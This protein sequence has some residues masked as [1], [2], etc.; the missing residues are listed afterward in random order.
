MIL[1]YI[2]ILIIFGFFISSIYQRMN[3]ID[4]SINI[5][6]K[7]GFSILNGFFIFS[8]YIYALGAFSLELNRML[9]LPILAID[10]IYLTYLI[11]KRKHKKLYIKK[12]KI[13]YQLVALI[14][15]LILLLA[16]GISLAYSNN[17]IYPDEFS[18]WGLNAKN[19]FIGHKLDFFI[20]TGL[21]K[22]PDFLPI[23]YGFYFI[24]VNKISE[25]VVRILPAILFI[26]MIFSFIG[27]GKKHNINS[28]LIILIFI[29]TTL[30]YTDI[31]QWAFSAYGDIVFSAFYTLAILYFFEWV[32]VDRSKSNFLF[33]MIYANGCCWTKID[34]IPMLTFNIGILI[35]YMIIQRFTKE[36]NM[37]PISL[38][39]FFSY[40]III[41][42]VGGSWILY[43]KLAHFP[44][45]LSAGAGSAFEFNTQWMAPLLT[46]M[47]KQQFTDI[48]WILTL[49]ILIIFI[50]KNW[51]KFTFNKKMYVIFCILNTLFIMFFLFL[52]YLTVFGGEALIA[53][54]YARY[55]SRAI[56]IFEFAAVYCINAKD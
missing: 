18:I 43:N 44:T 39:S 33:S 9:I 45:E 42:V 19:I 15:S 7:I 46:N 1:F 29:V 40:S 4:K 41:F 53:A 56:F 54:S 28:K 8:L 16:Y 51:N 32:I 47:T 50:I 35:L 3:L 36:K 34:G 49:I 21:E 5:Y 27:L 11:V 22:Y 38:K 30:F 20:N 10:L 55:L 31:S 24:L 25:N 2:V 52:C 26:G 6:E 48:V 17:F 14:A 23:I 13:D 12:I 37:K